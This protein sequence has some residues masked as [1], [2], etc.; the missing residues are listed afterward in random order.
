MENVTSTEA[1]A[2]SFEEDLEALNSEAEEGHRNSSLASTKR[3]LFKTV[4]K[5]DSNDLSR[6]YIGVK[7]YLHYFYE[8]PSFKDPSIYEEE[9]SLRYLLNPQRRRRRC[10]PIWW[11]IFLWLG[12]NLLFFGIV[13]ILVGY[14]VPQR[15]VIIDIN[16]NTKIAMV[17]RDAERYNKMLDVCKVIGLILF[18]AGGAIFSLSLLF[19]SF[20]TSYCEDDIHDATEE[21]FQIS[22]GDMEKRSNS[23]VEMTIP[24]T[25]ETKSVQPN[26]G[27]SVVVTDDLIKMKD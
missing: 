10:P 6:D 12:A 7:S 3:L 27:Q 5:Q 4:G 14:L 15:K 2:G 16:S 21:S 17:D 1:T 9:D 26:I 8:S 19:P 24:V 20:F 13:G 18:C 22:V 11:K 25:A 23:S